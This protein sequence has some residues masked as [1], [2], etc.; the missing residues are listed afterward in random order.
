MNFSIIQSLYHLIN[1]F[2]E[3]LDPEIIGFDTKI[4]ALV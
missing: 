2:N 4:N 1:E 3:F